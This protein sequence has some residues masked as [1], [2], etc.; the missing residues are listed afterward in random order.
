MNSS[1]VEYVDLY[2]PVPMRAQ[3]E[4]FDSMA[5]RV[6]EANGDDVRTSVQKR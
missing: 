5:V 1:S 6:A 2:H 3:G 4:L